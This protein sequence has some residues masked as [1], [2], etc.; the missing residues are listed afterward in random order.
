MRSLILI[1]L[2]ISYSASAQTEAKPVFEVASIKM[3]RATGGSGHSSENS[4]PG[5]LHGSMTLKSYIMAA[6][7]VKTYQ[8]TGGPNWVDDST[9]D[10][11]AKLEMAALPKLPAN[12]TPDQRA[13]AEEDRLHS[14]LQGL[15][16]DR[17]QLKLHHDAKEMP[18]YALTVVKSGFKLKETPE[19][20]GCGTNSKGNGTSINFTATCVD[21]TRF[22]SYLSRVT[23]QPV[24]DE[25]HLQ[26]SYSFGLEYIPDDLKTAASTDQPA[27]PSLFTILQQKLGLK[28]EQKKVPV[29]IFVVDRAERPSEN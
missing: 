17:F 16:A 22:A 6:Y 14:A 2:P 20:A 1:L 4:D 7:N 9:Y 15:L 23:R 29:D 25:T 10:I 26:G 28:L 11:V 8:V 5:L 24:S 3:V 21:M 19:T 12:L 27:L 18:A 13:T